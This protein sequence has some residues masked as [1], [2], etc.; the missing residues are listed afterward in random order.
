MYPLRTD[1]K[2]AEIRAKTRLEKQTVGDRI[3]FIRGKT[4]RAIFAKC[5][6]TSPATLKRYELGKGSPPLDFL[7]TFA[8]RE[9]LSHSWLNRG[10]GPVY[11]FQVEDAARSTP[12]REEIMDLVNSLFSEAMNTQSNAALLQRKLDGLS[13]NAAKLHILLRE[14][15]TN[16]EDR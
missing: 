16:P 11:A 2:M 7:T 8:L 13:H 12:D 3:R 1:E 15:L 6:A 9:G 5:H 10:E 4:P 14:F